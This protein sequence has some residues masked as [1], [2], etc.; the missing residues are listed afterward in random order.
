[1]HE[2]QNL[3]LVTQHGGSTPPSSI[4]IPLTLVHVDRALRGG[5]ARA[6]VSWF[7]RPV[8]LAARCCLGRISGTPHKHWRFRVLALC[9]VAVLERRRGHYQSTPLTN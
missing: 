7:C 2:T 8:R 1:T 3:A 9:C 5:F 6:G 4:N